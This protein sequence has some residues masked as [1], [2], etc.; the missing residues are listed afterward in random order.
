MQLCSRRCDECLF[1]PNRVVSLVRKRQLIAECRR[2]DTHFNC[3]KAPEGAERVC[4]GFFDELPGVGQLL[5]IMLRLKGVLTVDPEI[6]DP[7]T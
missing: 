4:R 1:G 3:H 5:R 2:L 7:T 6:G